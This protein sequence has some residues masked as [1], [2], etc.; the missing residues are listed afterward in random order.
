MPA[1]THTFHTEEEVLR[2]Q[3]HVLRFIA[4]LDQSD[5]DNGECLFL[6][7]N[8]TVRRKLVTVE[9]TSSRTLEAFNRY[10]RS[11]TSQFELNVAD[12]V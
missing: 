10:L 9:A 12:A 7:N 2:F 6:S 5:Q 1:Q 8:R 11:E 3:K 4:R